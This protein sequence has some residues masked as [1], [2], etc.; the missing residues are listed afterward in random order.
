MHTP[1]NAPILLHSKLSQELDRMEQ[2]GVILK[3]SELFDSSLE[4]PISSTVTL[5]SGKCAFNKDQVKFLHVGDIVDKVGTRADSV[6]TTAVA[7]VQTPCNVSE[8]RS[9]LSMNNHFGNIPRC[10]LW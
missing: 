8:L 6:K 9:F 4:M 2:A 1:C 7:N 10:Q 5:N 3:M